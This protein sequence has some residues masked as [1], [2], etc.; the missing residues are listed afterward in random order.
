MTSFYSFGSLS[1]AKSFL[2]AGVQ[3]QMQ[4]NLHKF[5]ILGSLSN[6]LGSGPEILLMSA[7][8]SL[9]TLVFVALLV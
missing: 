9:L 2:T 5:Q 3:K 7:E 1:E 8:V 4:L 6:I